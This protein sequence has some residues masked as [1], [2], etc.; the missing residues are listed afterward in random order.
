M[1]KILLLISVLLISG[2]LPALEDGFRYQLKNDP[3]W[4]GNASIYFD[5]GYQLPEHRIKDFLGTILLYWTKPE[6]R[7]FSYFM[8]IYEENHTHF[9]LSFMNNAIITVEDNSNYSDSAVDP[10]N[11]NYYKTIVTIGNSL[12]V[13]EDITQLY[14]RQDLDPTTA[15]SFMIKK[16]PHNATDYEYVGHTVLN[17]LEIGAVNARVMPLPDI[18]K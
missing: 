8:I 3:A 5:V 9:N 7:N 13:I 11:V 16:K 15:I 6:L 10:K 17:Q 14:L 4:N 12:P 18:L 2:C 1:K